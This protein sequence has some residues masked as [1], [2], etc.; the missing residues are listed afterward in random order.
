MG[1]YAYEEDWWVFTVAVDV[2]MYCEYID[3]CAF[4][5]SHIDVYMQTMIALPQTCDFESVYHNSSLK[6]T[7][8]ATLDGWGI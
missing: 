1:N 4:M 3:K 6:A 2:N 8:K 5:C 7:L